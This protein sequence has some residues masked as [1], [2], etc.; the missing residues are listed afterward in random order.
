M[1]AYNLFLQIM[2]GFAGICQSRQRFNIFITGLVT[3][4]LDR[5]F[6]VFSSPGPQSQDLGLLGTGP[7]SGPSKKPGPDQTLKH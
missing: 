5:F 4:S 7:S 2:S 6:P 3:T 1:S